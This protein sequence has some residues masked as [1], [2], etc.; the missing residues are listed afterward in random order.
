MAKLT[1]QSILQ[2][3]GNRLIKK[4]G[5]PLLYLKVIDKLIAC[6]TAVLGGHAHYCEKGH[7][8]G[9]W[10]NSCKHRFCPQ[11]RSMPSEEWLRNTKEILLDCAHHHIV[12]TLPSE[13]HD[14]WRYNRSLMMD[15]LFKASQ[16][17]LLEFAK[18][19]KY[20]NATLGILSTF[21]S[22]GRSFSLH[23]HTHV[24]VS[25]GG[26]NAAGEWVE[27]KKSCLF[28]QKAV[29]RMYRGKFLSMLKAAMKEDAWR[30]P[31]NYHPNHVTNLIN[32][33]GRK[34]WV[35][36][37]CKRYDYAKGVATYLARYV[38]SGPFKNSQLVS[39][40]D[41]DIT[42][43]YQSHLTKRIETLTLSVEAFLRRLLEHVPVPGKPTVRYCGLYNSAARK[44]LNTARAVLGQ[45]AVRKRE[46]LQWQ[47][48]LSDKGKLPV[49]EKCGLPLT[50]RIAV[51]PVRPVRKAA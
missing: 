28:P 17:T 32:K 11:C 34:D 38:K 46:S 25:Y 3:H 42:F 23:P 35:V 8:N 18:D 39:A 30:L 22:W 15:V 2:N 44:K 24:V 37:F 50:I 21:H 7:L 19:R 5:L 36:H 49:C 45:A 13:L 27:P 16:Q 4:M 31:P 1:L 51:A 14:I 43:K 47:E 48:F 41:Q 29:M 12:F 20:L 26:L 33:L 40:N 6:R 10:Y 9:L